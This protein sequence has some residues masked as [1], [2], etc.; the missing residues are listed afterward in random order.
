M[1]NHLV[2]P[3]LLLATACTS[4]EPLR[5]DLAARSVPSRLDEIAYVNGLRQAIE[6]VDAASDAGCYVGKDL[7][8]FRGSLEQG[9]PN[10]TKEE[11]NGR[12]EWCARFK[13]LGNEAPAAIDRYLQSGY[14]LTDLYCQRYFV[15]AV[16]SDRK[17]QF[18]R[19]MGATGDGLV[20]AVMAA[21]GAGPV[22]SQVSN[23]LFEGYD[24]TYQNIQ[25]A[26]MVSPDLSAV[27]K[28]VHEVQRKFKTD[29]ES[30][31][32][33]SYEAARQVIERYAGTCSYTGMKQMVNDSVSQQTENL[34]DASAAPTQGAPRDGGQAGQEG[35]GETDDTPTRP[36]APLQTPAAQVNSPVVG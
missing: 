36:A 24:S 9:Y 17:R 8:Y 21:A 3:A 11:E 23:A 14:G 10:H 26:F 6:Y 33:K 22:A 20:N 19:N 35:N 18:S 25:D 12:S 1:R 15:I 4:F 29:V 28:L 27:R 31:P 34:A 32:P 13:T 30:N 7:D 2:M 5:P 16:E